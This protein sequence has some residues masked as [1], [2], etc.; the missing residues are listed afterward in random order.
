M[1]ASVVHSPGLVALN[2]FS[3]QHYAGT[4]TYTADEFMPKV[5]ISG[6]LALSPPFSLPGSFSAQ[7]SRALS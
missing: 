4:V 7:C 1:S 3:V 5:T 6:S 2:G